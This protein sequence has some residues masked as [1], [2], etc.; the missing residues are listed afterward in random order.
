MKR[1]PSFFPLAVVVLLLTAAASQAR[2]TVAL[3][4]RELDPAVSQR[5]T[6]PERTWIIATDASPDEIEAARVRLKESGAR[7]VNLV[8]PDGVIVCELP[9]LKA[10]EVFAGVPGF[11]V[12]AESEIGPQSVSAMGRRIDWMLAAHRAVDAK[13]YGSKQPA[14]PSPAPLTEFEDVVVQLTPERLARAQ[15][16]IDAALAARP[17]P[18]PVA[19]QDRRAPNQ[20]SEVLAGDIAAQFIFPQSNGSYEPST[21]IWEEGDLVTARQGA[22]QMMLEWQSHF[23]SMDIHTT[24]YMVDKDGGGEPRQG[25]SHD[26]DCD[27]EPIQHNM[28]DDALWVLN[29]IRNAFP[30]VTAGTDDE[31]AATH[32]VNEYRRS[33]GYDWAFTAFVARSRNAPLH[34]FRDANYTAYA[35]L[36]GPY[37]V[38]PFPSGLDPNSIGELAVYSQILNHEGGHVF[39]T[40]DEYPGA[41]GTCGNTSGY[42]NYANGNI[43]IVD[44]FSGNTSRCQDL[45]T[46]I[47]HVA[48]READWGIGF[49]PWCSWSRGQMA[50]IDDN[51]NGVPDVFE[52]API[53]EFAVEGPETL[54]TNEVTISFRARAN[55]VKNRNH[56][57]GDGETAIDYASGVGDAF[58]TLGGS[59]T[60]IDLTPLDG[61]WGGELTEDFEFRMQLGTVGKTSIAVQTKNRAGYRSRPFFKDVYFIGVNYGKMDVVVLPDRIALSWDVV[62]EDFGAA[63]TL[64]RLEADEALP[65]TVVASNIQPSGPSVNGFTPYQSVDR[66]VKPG[67]EYRY[68]VDGRFT[69]VYEGA[70]REYFTES[71]T[72]V[73]TAMLEVP[74]GALV[75][76]ASPNPFRD[77]VSVSVSIPK[78]YAQTT[79]GAQQIQ[80]RVATAVDVSVFDVAGRRIRNLEQSS[81]FAS[82]LTLRWDGRDQKGNSVP[83][84]V[85]FI[86]ASAGEQTGVAKVLLLR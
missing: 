22:Y 14:S 77:E 3:D 12:R 27:Y 56:A 86:K 34:R 78:T 71:P 21:E 85:Y 30:T 76:R 9:P 41:P 35:N 24:I 17:G 4:V 19:V 33:R 64:Y 63:Y 6:P 67:T 29:V 84:G 66:S 46:C 57:F 75:S 38:Q 16:E 74:T 2:R 8:M 5:T 54:T 15:R 70:S 73:V 45:V 61:G 39:W 47:M 83:S 72:A 58:L 69:L 55:A 32:L 11:R 82:V 80:Q 26:A 68:Y 65:G 36:G 13:R 7:A 40:L 59:G 1:L 42:L 60:R 50:V 62:G 52:A 18:W 10:A 51:G 23:P 48:S 44:P 79:V 81:Q 31:I 20:N 43:T 53:V 37:L 49:R 25:G 28:S